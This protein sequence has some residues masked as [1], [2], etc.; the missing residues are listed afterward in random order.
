MTPEYDELELFKWMAHYIRR[1]EEI[2]DGE[3]GYVR[4]FSQLYDAG[5]IPKEYDLIMARIQ[6]LTPTKTDEQ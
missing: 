3:W 5:E 2:I 4:D 1:T 6:T